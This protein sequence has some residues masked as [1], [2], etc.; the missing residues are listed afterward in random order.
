MDADTIVSSLKFG[1]ISGCTGLL[2]GGT[3]GILRATKHPIVHT[4][5]H[6]IHFGLWG[7]SFWFI[8][9][10]ILHFHYQDDATRQQ[11]KYVSA[12]SGGLSGGI[13]GRLIGAKFTP[14][15]VVFSLLGYLG[16]SG[17]NIAERWHQE[18]EGKEASKPK[19][20]LERMAESK[21]IP[22]RA[23]SDDDF[24]NILKEK[25]LSIEVEIALLD[26]KIK[27]LEDERAAASLKESQ[28]AKD[29]GQK[30]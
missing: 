16:Q 25:V 27:S 28:N 5:A 4:V 11:R 1:G 13:V 26:E 3:S 24:R 22:L 21:W 10:N 17:W 29:E 6:G 7:T 15:F 14:G 12:I 30:N 2:Y 20:I 23:L 8:R 18:N 9:S 19:S